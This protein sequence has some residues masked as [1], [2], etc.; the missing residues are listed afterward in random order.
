LICKENATKLRE[1]PQ[2][3]TS[4]MHSTMHATVVKKQM[5]VFSSLKYLFLSLASS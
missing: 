5:K 1:F 3:L 4:F 2:V